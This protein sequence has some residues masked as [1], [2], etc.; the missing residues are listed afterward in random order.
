MSD[1]K[2]I[3][4]VEDDQEL[5]Q[6]VDEY[7][8]YQGFDVLVIDNGIDATDS[9][10]KNQPD[11]VILDL[12][13]PGKDGISVCRDVR[14][15]YKGPILMLTASDEPIDQVVGLEIGADDFVHKPIEP[16]ILL[17]R[18]RALS[19]RA[20]INQSKTPISGSSAGSEDLLVAN[21]LTVNKANRNVYIKEELFVLNSQEFD[22]LC[23]LAENAGNILSRDFLFQEMKGFEYDGLNRFID[24]LISQIRNKINDHNACIIKTVRG[25]G[26]LLVK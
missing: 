25:K 18:I 12:M 22:L 24:I 15:E 6:L 13:L 7:L 10:I 4:L 26:Y 20:E 11:L 16:R 2:Q 21:D 8:S 3:I 17:A 1:K 5:A 9:I 23:I 14:G 19:R